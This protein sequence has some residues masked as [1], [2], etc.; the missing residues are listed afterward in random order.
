[1]DFSQGVPVRVIFSAGSLLAQSGWEL[2]VNNAKALTYKKPGVA[3]SAAASSALLKEEEGGLPLQFELP[4]G[5]FSAGA[6]QIEVLLYTNA[7]V[8]TLESL[9]RKSTRLNSSYRT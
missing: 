3:A 5:F 4:T 6:N 9:D 8:N 7:A 1:M 2:Y